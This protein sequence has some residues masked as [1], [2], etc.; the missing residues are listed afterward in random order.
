MVISE[1]TI[2]ESGI[3]IMIQKKKALVWK[4]KH[5]ELAKNMETSD[6]LIAKLNT[7]NNDYSNRITVLENEVQGLKIQIKESEKRYSKK[8][9]DLKEDFEQQ[10]KLLRKDHEKQIMELRVEMRENDDMRIKEIRQ[11]D[12]MNSKESRELKNEMRS[13]KAQIEAI[14]RQL[15]RA[16]V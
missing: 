3:Q 9:K 2:N 13:M 15:G 16:R 1:N 10:I 12:E 14:M 4:L 7:I 5:T 6:E 11:R 8:L